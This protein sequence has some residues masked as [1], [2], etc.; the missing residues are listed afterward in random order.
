[1]NFTDTRIR[2]TLLSNPEEAVELQ[3][4]LMEL[5][6]DS[7]FDALGAFQ[8]TSAV[9]EAVNNCIKHAYAGEEGQPITLNWHRHHDSVA[10]ELRDGGK[11]LPLRLLESPVLAETD[12]ESG[13]GWHIIH[14]WSDHVSYAREGEENVLTLTR[15]L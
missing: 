12:A 6:T 13:R 2:F 10:I 3:Q 7:G 9:I 5:C 14:A 4:K 11:P 1:M 15:R 8:F